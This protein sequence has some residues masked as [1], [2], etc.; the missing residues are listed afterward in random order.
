[1]ATPS[2]YHYPPLDEARFFRLA[3]AFD[4]I[5]D[6]PEH[7]LRRDIWRRLNALDDRKLQRTAAANEAYEFAETTRRIAKDVTLLG[8]SC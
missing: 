6:D 1:M 5:P 7:R 2:G 4:A 3:E 8:E